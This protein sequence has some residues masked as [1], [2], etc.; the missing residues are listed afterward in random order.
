MV[1]AE[2]AGL[3][4]PESREIIMAATRRN[5]I[6]ASTIAL[7]ICPQFALAAQTISKTTQ[8]DI[9]V[10]V[11]FIGCKSD[12]QVGPQKAP[13]AAEAVQLLPRDAQHLAY[14]QSAN[15]FGVLAPR[16][17]YCFG[18]YGSNGSTLY[19][20]PKPINSSELFSDSWKGF[21]GPAI[22]LSISL[23]DTSGRFAV[24]RMIARVF[25]AYKEFATNVV[26][27][28]IEPAS[29]F[30]WGPYPKDKLTYRGKNIV[31]YVTPGNTDGLGTHSRLQK[32][33]NPIT[34][35]AILFGEAPDLLQLT[36]RLPKEQKGL[37]LLIVQQLEGEAAKSF[38]SE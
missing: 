29:S 3:W 23:G 17:W 4:F 37:G 36:I 15:G 24:A 19:V 13:T 12:G 38:S 35:V 32:N 8:E 10:T 30:P 5:P 31:E 11:H 28:G 14:Y 18:T 1:I 7:A 2:R 16:G 26:D 27:E 33:A 34:G 21:S 6:I 20:S 25:P 9:R 22:Q